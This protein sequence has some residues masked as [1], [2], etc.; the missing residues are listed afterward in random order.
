MLQLCLL[1]ILPVSH[2]IL[3]DCCGLRGAASPA[4][5]LLEHQCETGGKVMDVQHEALAYGEKA[6]YSA[7]GS[8]RFDGKEAILFVEDAPFVREVTSEVLRSHGYEVLAAKN[9]DEAIRIYDQR[10]GEVDLLLTD[11]VLPGEN[12]RILAQ[13]L[14]KRNPR[15]KVLLVSGYADQMMAQETGE[16][17][18]AKP[19][20]TAMLVNKIRQRLACKEFVGE[21]RCFVMRACGSV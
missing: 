19:F 14:R 4:L 1:K 6:L 13:S 8:A 21:K 20:N 2:F 15:L 11:I 7:Q 3:V 10:C 16:E 17:C 5:E 18:I 12:G 9:A